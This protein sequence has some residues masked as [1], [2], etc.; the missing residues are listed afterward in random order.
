PDQ[1]PPDQNFFTQGLD[2][3]GA[4]ELRNAL[5]NALGV[6]LSPTVVFDAESPVGLAKLIIG[7]DTNTGTEASVAGNA[8]DSH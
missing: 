7:L 5:S 3:L 8:P 6:P 4:V 1:V 2:S